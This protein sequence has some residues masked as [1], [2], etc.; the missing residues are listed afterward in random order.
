M[1]SLEIQVKKKCRQLFYFSSSRV[2]MGDGEFLD[3]Q[4]HITLKIHFTRYAV[5]YKV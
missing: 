5:R 4:W 2:K 1:F 3:A